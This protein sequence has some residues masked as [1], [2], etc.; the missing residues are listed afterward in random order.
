MVAIAALVL[1]AGAMAEALKDRTVEGALLT[2][3][4]AKQVAMTHPLKVLPWEE[5]TLDKFL[6]END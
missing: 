4:L 3:E 6:T 5:A 1:G 2:M